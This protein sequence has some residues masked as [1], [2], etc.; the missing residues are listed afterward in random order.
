LKQKRNPATL[1][2][3]SIAKS[4]YLPEK[5]RTKAGGIIAQ[6]ASINKRQVKPRQK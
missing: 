4:F 3:Y 2:R 6:V 1:M 5:G